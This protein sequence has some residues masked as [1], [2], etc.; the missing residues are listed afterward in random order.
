M[1]RS[2]PRTDGSLALELDFGSGRPITPRRGV[3]LLR[4]RGPDK[5]AVLEHRRRQ[6]QIAARRLLQRMEGD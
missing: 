6:A 1:T 2:Q 4:L 5:Y 3:K